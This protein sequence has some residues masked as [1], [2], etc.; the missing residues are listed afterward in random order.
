MRSGKQAP[1]SASSGLKWIWR[2]LL[3]NTVN[4]NIPN[5]DR[6]KEGRRQNCVGMCHVVKAP[7]VVRRLGGMLTLSSLLD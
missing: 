1:T 5:I 4:Q 7:H 6:M 2:N 3:M